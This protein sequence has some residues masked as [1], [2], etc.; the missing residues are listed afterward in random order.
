MRDEMAV[1]LRRH[2]RADDAV[3]CVDAAA[4]RDPSLFWQTVQAILLLALP[5]HAYS[6]VIS[7]SSSSFSLICDQN[8]SIPCVA[9]R[10]MVQNVVAQTVDDFFLRKQQV[11]CLCIKRGRNKST[12]TYSK[13]QLGNNNEQKD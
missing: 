2:A 7:A 10:F 13:P 8:D 4:F 11:Q 3:S 5:P 12:S 9:S 6:H 1:E